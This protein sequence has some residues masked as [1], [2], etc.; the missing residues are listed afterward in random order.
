[1]LKHGGF[2]SLAEGLYYL[3]QNKTKTVSTSKLETNQKEKTNITKQTTNL[4]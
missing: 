4:I 1:M 2:Y 3:T